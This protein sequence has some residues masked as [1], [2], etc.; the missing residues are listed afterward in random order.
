M[1]S[2]SVVAPQGGRAQRAE[3]GSA[4]LLKL[5][6]A[7]VLLLDILVLTVRC[8]VSIFQS[9]FQLIVPPREKSVSGETVLITGTGHGMGRELAVKFAALGA[10]L[11]LVDINERGNAE[12]ARLVA[13]LTSKKPPPAYRCDVSRRED[14]LALAAKVRAEVG[15]VTVLVNNAGIMPTHP[16]LKHTPE[17]IKKIFDI[18]VLAHFWMLEAFLPSMIQKNHGHVVALS[19]MAGTMGLSNLV[20]Y[21]ASKFAVRGLMEAISEELREDA[22]NINVKFTTICPFMVDTG[23]CEKP[24]IKFPSILSMLGPS[25]A[26]DEIITAMRRNY[27]EV[28]IPRSLL[29]INNVCRVFPVKVCHLIKDFLDSGVDAV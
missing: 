28:S 9:T 2:N 27:H 19:S 20:P 13:E 11:V 17:E 23:L 10:N 21:C 12:T 4:M 25:E 6:S 1:A 7:L 22:R 5:Y 15:E 29:N 3:G 24:R 16:L 26:A 14:V 18:N 8:F